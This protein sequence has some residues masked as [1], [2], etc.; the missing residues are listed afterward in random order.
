MN[1]REEQDHMN[2]IEETDYQ[3]K[4]EDAVLPFLKM[5]RY[6]GYFSPDGYGDIYFERYLHD[7]ANGIV[8][9][10]HGF[11]ESAE[12]YAEIIYYFFQAGYQVYISDVRGHGRSVRTVD[13]LSMIHIDRYD[14]YLT[15]LEYL[16]ENIA[17][18]ENPG[19]PLYLYGHSMGGGISAAFLEK[20]PDLFQKAILTS[21]M[22]RPLTGGVPFCLARMIA[23]AQ[24]LIG[25]GQQYVVG[26]HVFQADEPFEDSPS[27]CKVR[28]EYYYAKRLSE[29]RFQTTGA[30][31]SWLR[32]ATRLSKNILKKKNCNRI[33]APILL[34]Q[35]EDE[36][37][38]DNS[39]QERF[40]NQV[41]SVTLI[42]VAGTKHEIYMST[43]HIILEYMD[44]ILSFLN[45]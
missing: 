43:D 41:E 6:H 26:Q 40:A 27:V 1:K 34:F 11:S 16:A 32:A 20:R 24:T 23:I 29:E 21:P 28:Y 33:Q 14:S 18:K 42:P 17:K 30:S 5:Y 7:R 8:V 12:K 36:T 37:F 25:H 19:L 39:A 35:A 10:V 3:R 38:V 2:I 22:I 13:D 45:I 9:I 44:R 4:M 15:D 31:Y